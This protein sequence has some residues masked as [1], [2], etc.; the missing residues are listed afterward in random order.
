MFFGFRMNFTSSI[1]R[2]HKGSGTFNH[3]HSEPSY[4]RPHA[5]NKNTLYFHKVGWNLYPT[6][7]S[8]HCGHPTF[9]FLSVRF[10]SAEA[11]GAG[12]AWILLPD[13]QVEILKSNGRHI[14]RK[15]MKRFRLVTIIVFVWAE[16][17][18]HKSTEHTK[19]C[20]INT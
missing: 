17:G 8:S 12:R 1:G 6:V 16:G 13:F 9:E 15:A 19:I 2:H 14:L 20:W 3:F 7:E 18:R 11:S 5:L 10:N 4:R